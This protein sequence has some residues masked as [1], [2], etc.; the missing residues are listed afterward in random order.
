MGDQ[1]VL[2][3]HSRRE[4][5]G[6]NMPFTKASEW[7]GNPAAGAVVTWYLL[8]YCNDDIKLVS[9]DIDPLLDDYQDNT[10]AVIAAMIE[11][12]IL[13]DYGKSYVDD[14]EPDFIFIR[15]LRFRASYLFPHD[16]P[17]TYIA[18]D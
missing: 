12:G 7:V 8:Q 16:D 6:S 11:E 13:A 17:S 10:A 3:N 9:K 18:I 4:W 2:V 5:I 15:D 14:D 1:Y